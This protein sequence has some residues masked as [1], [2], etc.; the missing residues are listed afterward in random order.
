MIRPLP[1]LILF[2]MPV[3]ALAQRQQVVGPHIDYVFPAGAQRGTAVEVTVGGQN[4]QGANAVRVSGQGITGTVAPVVDPKT[5]AVDPKSVKL[6]LTL[7]PDAQLGEREIRIISPK[8]ASNRARFLVGQFP[9]VK[10]IEPNSEKDKAQRI[11]S[12]PVVINGQIMQGDLDYFRITAKAGQM[13]VFQVDA[14][15]LLPFIADAVPGWNDVCLTLYN[16]EGRQ[17]ASVDDFRF[18]PDPVLFFQVPQDGDYL[19]EVRDVIFRGRA[20]FVY[21]LTIGTLPYITHAYPLGGRRGT[22]TKVELFGVNLPERFLDVA[23]P[24]D[25]PPRRAIQV[26][27]NGIA[28][29][30]VRFAAGDLPE[31]EEKEPNNSPEQAM[32]VEAPVTINGRIQQPGDEDYFVFAAKAKQ[33]LIFDVL[34]RRLDSPLDSI[35]T[36]YNSK[37]Q[38]LAENDDAVDEGEGLLTH[39]A[40]SRLVYTIPADGDYTIR[41]RDVQGKGGQEYAYRLTI[42][43]VQPNFYL[44]ISPDNPQ[45]G[46]GDTAVIAITAV[47]KDGFNGEIKLAAQDLPKGFV[48]SDAAIAE[49][50]TVAYMTMTSP[51]DAAMEFYSPAVVGTATVG[52]QTVTRKA[53]PAEEQMQAFSFRHTVPTQELLLSVKDTPPFVLS[54]KLPGD[55]KILEIQQGTEAQIVVRAT[56]RPQPEP[57]PDPSKP[58][59]KPPPKPPPKDPNAER[60]ALAAANPP[61]PGITV[62]QAYL[63]ADKEEVTITIK[64]EPWARPEIIQNLILGGTRYDAGQPLTRV[65]PAI[66]IR[67]LKP[68]EKKPPEKKPAPLAK[69]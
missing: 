55:K 66:P 29:N 58:P 37:G 61:P 63:P 28:S 36:L 20:D 39:H 23:L 17:L 34:A 12:L 47:R 15:T 25:S 40:D 10:E 4:L 13:L 6:N 56:R 68:P 21:R 16:A 65:A 44:Y 51:P 22:T 54:V 18:K 7:A 67:V 42:A 53:L 41:I 19:V 57:K 33:Q 1:A 5:K 48:A 62:P 52:A 46:Q 35:L 2:L 26:T 27:P 8:G 24:A 32:R 60:I 9:E 69:K 49:N 11:E 14:R 43:P 59:A 31:V 64:A 30:A 38:E 3:V 50:Q 45:M